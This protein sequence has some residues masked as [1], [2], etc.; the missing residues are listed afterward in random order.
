MRVPSGFGKSYFRLSA[1][2]AYSVA[3][4]LMAQQSSYVRHLESY[5]KAD[6]EHEEEDPPDE[7]L[8]SVLLLSLAKPCHCNRFFQQKTR[9]LLLFYHFIPRCP[10]YTTYYAF[11]RSGVHPPHVSF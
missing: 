11:R 6:G 7:E 4:L 10:Y 1:I 8:L 9:L 3:P 2:L 5:F